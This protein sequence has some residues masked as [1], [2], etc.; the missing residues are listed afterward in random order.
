MIPLRLVRTKNPGIETR[1]KK[2][3][4]RFLLWNS[5]SYHPVA[6]TQKAFGIANSVSASLLISQN[7]K[8]L[9]EPAPGFARE[10]SNSSPHPPRTSSCPCALTSTCTSRSL[11]LL[12]LEWADP[13][14][15][16]QLMVWAQVG[17]ARFVQLTV[18]FS[19]SWISSPLLDSYWSA[20]AP[21]SSVMQA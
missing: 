21:H 3:Y 14:S 6:W 20:L 12:L 19:W 18:Y 8:E 16:H 13:A 10:N 7:Y 17:L 15:C 11:L 1:L 4:H 9:A 2:S 5:F